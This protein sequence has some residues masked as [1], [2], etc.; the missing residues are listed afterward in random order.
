MLSRGRCQEERKILQ[1]RDIRQASEHHSNLK[2]SLLARWRKMLKPF[3]S[4]FRE[5]V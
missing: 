1:K 5:A 2:R 3:F 4:T